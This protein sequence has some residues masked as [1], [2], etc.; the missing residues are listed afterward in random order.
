MR[1]RIA[2]LGWDLMVLATIGLAAFGGQVLANT[3]PLFGQKPVV[4][5]LVI[6]E[7]RLDA[8]DEKVNRKIGF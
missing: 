7:E 8:L 4:T 5:R 2:N 3:V 1:E 6:I